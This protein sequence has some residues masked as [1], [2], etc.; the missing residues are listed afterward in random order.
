M[1]LGEKAAGKL[2]REGGGGVGK[3]GLGKGANNPG[4]WEPRLGKSPGGRGPQEGTGG[5]DP[6]KRGKTSVG[7]LSGDT[8]G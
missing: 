3:P 4:L 7:G 6:R 2:A 1:S 5:V 8:R